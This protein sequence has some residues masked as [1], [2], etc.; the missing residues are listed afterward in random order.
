[1]PDPS[2]VTM[3]ASVVQHVGQGRK[4]GEMTFWE[5]GGCPIYTSLGNCSRARKG[6]AQLLGTTAVLPE[7]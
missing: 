7:T 3:E 2:A 5:L 4:N 6:L 1:M